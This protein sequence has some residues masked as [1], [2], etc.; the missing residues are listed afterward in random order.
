[1]FL[2]DENGENI[3]LEVI[4]FGLVVEKQMRNM[5]KIIWRR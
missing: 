5:A 4:E 2:Y 3:R 1:M